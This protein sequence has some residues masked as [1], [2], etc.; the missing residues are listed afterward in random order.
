MPALAK[1][2]ATLALPPLSAV[3]PRVLLPLRKVTVPV[4]LDPVTFAVR[5]VLCPGL[6]VLLLALSVVW[7]AAALT[8]SIWAGE[9]L[10]LLA[11][12]PL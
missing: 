2:T 9:T 12:S 4:G 11:L 8:V 10:V 1:A 5:V 7:L 3:L 6:G